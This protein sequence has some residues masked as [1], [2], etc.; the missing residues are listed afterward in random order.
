MQSE[1]RCI[2]RGGA[3][4]QVGVNGVQA[5]GCGH[6]GHVDAN[7]SFCHTYRHGVDY[8]GRRWQAFGPCGQVRAEGCLFSIMTSTDRENHQSHG[9]LA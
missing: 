7:P 5:A 3:Y 1:R 8:S 2:I 4:T 9:G 6:V